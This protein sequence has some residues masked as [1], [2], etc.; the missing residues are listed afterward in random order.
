MGARLLAAIEALKKTPWV[1][2]A[3]L[4]ASAIGA[5][6]QFTGA[7]KNLIDLVRP[8][9]FDPRGE[10]AKLGIPYTPEAMAKAATDGDTR[11]VELLLDAGMAPSSRWGLA[12]P[13]LVVAARG[14]F[15]ETARRLRDAGADPAT[16]GEADSALEAAVKSHH[17]DVVKM[18]LEH[19]LPSMAIR[20]AYIDAAAIGDPTELALL[21]PHLADPKRTARDAIAAILERTPSRLLPMSTKVAKLSAAHP[22]EPY[23]QYLTGSDGDP[24]DLTALRAVLSLVPPLDEIDANGQTLLHKAADSDA[25]GVVGA[26]LAAGANPNVPGLCQA[27]DEARAMPLACAVVRGT[28]LGL[29][30]TRA[31]VAGH[32]DVDARDANGATPL[33]LAAGNGDADV[34]AILIKAGANVNARD[35]NGRN[36]REYARMAR[37]KTPQTTVTLKVEQ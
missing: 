36:A 25:P 6:A 26:L 34:G 3:L 1:V 11:A 19:R 18:L 35:H 4:L 37:F 13:P 10:L 2:L 28:S 7:T 31:L 29:A 23:L 22:D 8:T 24:R 14:G 20:D 32:A 30:T 12:P 5:L 15:T 27:R 21:A 17:P 16:P 33:M 9:N